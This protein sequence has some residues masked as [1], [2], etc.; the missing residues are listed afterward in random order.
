MKR[1]DGMKTATI[2][3][4]IQESLSTMGHKEGSSMISPISK[5]GVFHITG[6]GVY[7]RVHHNFMEITGTRFNQVVGKVWLQSIYCEDRDRVC[8]DWYLSIMKDT[9]FTATF[10]IPDHMHGGCK[11]VSCSLVPEPSDTNK[12]IGYFGIFVETEHYLKAV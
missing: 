9:P 12:R 2:K 5:I 6:S 7:D 8:K 4:L 1:G 11:H 3:H 10:R